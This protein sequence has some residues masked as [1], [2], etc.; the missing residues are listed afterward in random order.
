MAHLR[1]DGS[2]RTSDGDARRRWS[3]TRGSAATAAQHEGW[4][5]GHASQAVS[6]W[7]STLWGVNEVQG[8]F[9]YTNKYRVI[10][11]VKLCSVTMAERYDDQTENSRSK[12]AWVRIPR[13]A[14]LKFFY[15][16]LLFFSERP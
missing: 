1:D 10:R 12:L 14:G 13:A 6:G 5:E 2:G 15:F 7:V 11:L 9:D 4:K 8:D 3:R 16:I